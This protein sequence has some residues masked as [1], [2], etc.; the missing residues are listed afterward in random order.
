[1]TFSEVGGI[2][3]NSADETVAEVTSI[4]DDVIEVK[5]SLGGPTAFTITTGYG[6]VLEYTITPTGSGNCGNHYLDFDDSGAEIITTVTTTETTTTTET[7]NTTTIS[8]GDNTIGDVNLDGNISLADTVVLSKYAADVVSLS[9][10]A[11]SS[12]DT[13][14]DGSV[15]VNDALILL[16]F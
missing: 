3:C 5:V 15:D 1:M 10:L 12:A 7:V 16:K 2:E 6:Q 9:D 14:G 8:E 11:Y 4:S 13:N